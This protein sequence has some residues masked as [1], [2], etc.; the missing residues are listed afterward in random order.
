MFVTVRT[1]PMS[2][3]VVSCGCCIASSKTYCKDEQSNRTETF[4]LCWHGDSLPDSADSPKPFGCPPV[5]GQGL[6][7]SAPPGRPRVRQPAKK[8]KE[9]PFPAL[10]SVC[11]VYSTRT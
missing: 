5:V 3:Y 4:L 9:F 1:S 2:A 11:E 8:A 7:E 10:P 6:T